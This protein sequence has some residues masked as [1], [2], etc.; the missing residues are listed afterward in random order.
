LT[1]VIAE[2]GS[3]AGRSPRK[4][5]L[6]ARRLDSPESY[7]RVKTEGTVSRKFPL[8]MRILQ[9][10]DIT[11]SRVGFVVRKRTGPAPLRN[12]MRRVLRELFRERSATFIRPAWIVFDVAEAAG[13]AP[14]VTRREFRARADGLLAP[15]CRSAA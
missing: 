5:P 11:E 8:S 6:R 2:T 15:L 12:A 9:A 4:F 7:R 14:E 1:A 10:D 3:N 13:K